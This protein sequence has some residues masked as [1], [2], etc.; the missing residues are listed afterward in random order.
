MNKIDSIYKDFL[1]SEEYQKT[2][3]DMSF[4]ISWLEGKISRAEMMRLEEVVSDYG[5]S[6]SN[7]LFECGFRYAWDLLRE[8]S[9]KQ[10]DESIQPPI[11]RKEGKPMNIRY[12]CRE[13][14]NIQQIREFLLHGM[15]ADE[16]K[17]G[18]HQERVERVREEF[19]Q[20]LKETFPDKEEYGKAADLLYDY[21]NAVEE[22]YMEMGM[23]CG[24]GILFQL[25]G[26]KQ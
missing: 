23:Q 15:E 25:L 16:I 14:M 21:V 4:D 3:R 1:Y 24:A 5:V 17:P 12:E 19:T 26:G 2:F 7:A 13:R 20:L 8:L 6:N 9:G 18:S 10:N 11:N 22:V